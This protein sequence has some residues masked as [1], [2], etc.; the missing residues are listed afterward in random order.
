MKKRSFQIALSALSCALATVFMAVGLN[1][2]FL[3]I[4]GYIFAGIALMLPLAEDFRAGGFL[5]FAATA[6]LCLPFGGIAYFYKLFPFIAFFGLHPL[7]NSLQR[8]YKIRRWVAWAVKAVWFDG[9][10]CA[11]W[12]LFSE[13]FTLPFAWMEDW[14]YLILIVGGAVV[15]LPYDWLMMRAQGLVDH[16]VAKAGRRPPRGKPPQ[17]S[18]VRDDLGDVF[19]ED[20]S[21]GGADGADGQEGGEQDR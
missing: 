3:F 5:A 2:S 6:L 7:V 1:V 15:F 13:L 8:K 21:A 16:Y 9:M 12:A 18:G 19:G 20:A 4:T 17:A 14:I 10:L 11:A